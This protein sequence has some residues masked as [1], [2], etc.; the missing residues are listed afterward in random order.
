[1]QLRRRW[2]Q[3]RRTPS[4][5]K[6]KKTKFY[7][8]RIRRY[9]TLGVHCPLRLHLFKAQKQSRKGELKLS[10]LPAP[11]C[12]R[13]RNHS[14]RR[15]F[16][17]TRLLTLQPRVRAQRNPVSEAGSTTG[18]SSGACVLQLLRR[19]MMTWTRGY[20]RRLEF[21]YGDSWRTSGRLRCSATSRSR[22]SRNSGPGDGGQS[23]ASASARRRHVGRKWHIRGWS[24]DGRDVPSL[25]RSLK[26]SG[27][28]WRTGGDR[29]VVA[30]ARV[31]TRRQCW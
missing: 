30:S 28:G 11:T 7:L 22:N 26:V 5:V 4:V 24:S 2:T 13:T 20:G 8:T 9:L 17:T 3:Y 31:G 18:T 10:V 21:G 29:A 14:Q 15:V 19:A 27:E 1:M 6:E 23:Y 12:Y 16:R 25:V